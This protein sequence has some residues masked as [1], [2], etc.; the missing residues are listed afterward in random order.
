MPSPVD[1]VSTSFTI[2]QP[3]LDRLYERCREIH[4]SR[5]FVVRL[6]LAEF[7]KRPADPAVK[8]ELAI[9]DAP[10]PSRPTKKASAK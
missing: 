2:D 9:L 4:R 5:S 10:A 6:A 1:Y 8:R 7:L 3:L